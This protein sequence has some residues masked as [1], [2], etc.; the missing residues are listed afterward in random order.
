MDIVLSLTPLEFQII[1]EVLQETV[2]KGSRARDL[3]NLIDKFKDSPLSTIEP[4]NSP[5]NGETVPSETPVDA[6]ATTEDVTPALPEEP[7]P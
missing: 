4:T 6:P 2:V 1:S 5:E 7:V 3:A